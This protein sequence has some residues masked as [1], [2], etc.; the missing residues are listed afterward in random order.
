MDLF[1]DLYQLVSGICP[2]HADK[3]TKARKT[4]KALK[5]QLAV[6]ADPELP[7]GGVLHR[8]AARAATKA[9]A[10]DY[11]RIVPPLGGSAGLWTGR[12]PGHYSGADAPSDKGPKRHS[13]VEDVRVAEG[14][15]VTT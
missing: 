2:R 14:A 9:P 3:N 8:T 11:R 7:R 13:E 10:L 12:K 6:T 15:H 5:F 4:C 1:L